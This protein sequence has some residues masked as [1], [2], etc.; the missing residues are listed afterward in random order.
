MDSLPIKT[1]KLKPLILSAEI[2]FLAATQMLI[3]TN[4]VSFALAKTSR[5]PLRK[6]NKRKNKTIL[7]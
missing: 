7:L 6:V 1:I 3:A 4:S 5:P 2:L